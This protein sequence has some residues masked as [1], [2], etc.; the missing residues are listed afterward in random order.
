MRNHCAAVRGAEANSRVE[1]FV[2]VPQ[3]SD[4][5]CIPCVCM[6]VC[7]CVCVCGLGVCV[8]CGVVLSLCGSVCVWVC[9]LWVCLCVCVC[10]VLVCVCVWCV[11]RAS[12]S[13]GF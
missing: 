13:C 11:S 2:H 9:V 10:G 8:C 6:H 7:L 5:L 12:D 3:Q 1:L 4:P